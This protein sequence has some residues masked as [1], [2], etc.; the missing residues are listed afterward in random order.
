M[1]QKIR[2]NLYLRPSHIQQMQ[3][4]VMVHQGNLYLFD[5]GYFDDEVREIQALV[6]DLAATGHARTEVP[7]TARTAT[8]IVLTHSDYDHIAGVPYFP[9][10]AVLAASTWDEDN[11]VRSI[12]QIESFD[13]EFYVDRPWQGKM[14]RIRI[15]QRLNDGDTFDGLYFYHAKGH[16]DDGLVTVCD[17][18]AVVGDY[19]S[20]LEFPFIY[21][22]YRSYEETMRHFRAV[23]AKHDV[24]LVVTQ[25]G[26]HADGKSEIEHRLAISEDY[27][28][29]LAQVVQEGLAAGHDLDDVVR[30]SEVQ[31]RFDG[32]PLSSGIVNMHRANVRLT[33]QEFGGSSNER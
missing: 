17:S 25:H 12:A 21:T 15:D 10:C 26:P 22:S 19:L 4:A 13:S 5:P 23:F 16:T 33:W 27:L 9:G 18:V 24:D 14:E 28:A 31:M 3:S 29:E 30:A 8:R 2:E 6:E 32:K 7:D 1:I 20:A 11:E